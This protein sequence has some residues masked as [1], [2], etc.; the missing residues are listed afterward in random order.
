MVDAFGDS[1]TPS[2]SPAGRGLRGKFLLASSSLNDPNFAHTVVLIVRH[3]AEGA[4]GV[5]LNRPLGLTVDDACSEEV[6]A[7][8]GVGSLLHQGGPCPGPLVAVHNVE[9]VAATEPEMAIPPFGSE[10]DEAGEPWS[11]PV[12]PGI[13]FCARREA[14]EALMLRVN[15]P[16]DAPPGTAVKFIVG[17]SGWG[18]GQL[19]EELAQGSWLI[20]DATARDAYAGTGP[21][22]PAPPPTTTLPPGA[23][24]LVTL[25]RSAVEARHDPTEAL[26]SGI[27]QWVRLSTQ[28][29]LRRY[30]DARFIPPD[31]SV[32]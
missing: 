4:L 18:A 15:D 11:E 8:R 22:Y 29:G 6:E 27:R 30:V 31:P 3:D 13:W 14:L 1:P 23:V 25:L 9:A 24:A 10:E 16:A 2:P 26:A 12:S 7:A 5:I 21:E 28:A 32:N 20:A 17:H 19:E